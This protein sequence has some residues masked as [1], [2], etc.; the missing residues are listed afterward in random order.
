M[1]LAALQ[2]RAEDWEK[3]HPALSTPWEEGQMGSEEVLELVVET[4]QSAELEVLSLDE[5][6]TYQI[7]KYALS[8]QFIY[9]NQRVHKK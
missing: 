7:N 5:A 2:E 9:L 4:L 8:F 6:N 3:L 1:A